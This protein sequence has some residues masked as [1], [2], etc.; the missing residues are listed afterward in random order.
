MYDVN[1]L[2]YF[3]SLKVLFE[4]YI[5]ETFSS[6]VTFLLKFNRNEISEK[7]F[8]CDEIKSEIV[9]SQKKIHL[10]YDST[11]NKLVNIFVLYGIW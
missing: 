4:K 1:Q 9:P 3:V 2:S 11:K 10:T 7:N 6:E 8:N 5:S